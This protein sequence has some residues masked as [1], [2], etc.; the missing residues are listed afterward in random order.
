MEKM[1]E[2]AG[3]ILNHHISGYHQYVL[4]KPVHL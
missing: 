4:K 1:L 3:E 2:N